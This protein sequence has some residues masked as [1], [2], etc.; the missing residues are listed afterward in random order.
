M[1]PF[2]PGFVIN[3]KYR[4]TGILGQGGMGLVYRAVQLGLH[5]TVALKVTQLASKYESNE[6]LAVREQRFLREAQMCARL[7]H[8]NVVTV[9]DFGEVHNLRD[10]KSHFIAMEYLEGTTLEQRIHLNP[11]GM[12]SGDVVRLILEVARGLRAA[13]ARRLV[14]RDLKPANVMMVPGDEKEQVKILDFGLVL[15]ANARENLTMAG[16]F[17]G[18]PAYMAPEQIEAGDVDQQVDIYALGTIMYECLVGSL[19]FVCRNLSELFRAKAEHK[20]E[21]ISKRNPN[22]KVSFPL[23]QLTLKMMARERKDRIASIDEVIKI[24][25]DTPEA[26]QYSEVPSGLYQVPP[27]HMVRGQVQYQ[28]GRQLSGSPRSSVFQ[29]ND[30]VTGG[31]VVVKIFHANTPAEKQLLGRELPMLCLLRNYRFAAVF[32][33]GETEIEQRKVPFLVME[34]V[35]GESLRD[36]QKKSSMISEGLAIHLGCEVLLALADAHAIRVV[37]RE[38]NHDTILLNEENDGLPSVKIIGF[39]TMAPVME[40]SALRQR[41]SPENW[42]YLAPESLGTGVMDENSDLFALAV[43]LFEGLAGRSLYAD[44]DW[45]QQ[46]AQG[47]V[48]VRRALRNVSATSEELVSVIERALHEDPEKRFSSARAFYQALKGLRTSLRQNVSSHDFLNVKVP[49]SSSHIKLARQPKTIWILEGD[50][51][52]QAEEVQTSLA[53]LRMSFELVFLNMDQR[54]EL[55]PM[56]QSGKVLPPWL[57]IFGDL[58]VLLDDELLKTLSDFSETSK[59]IISSHANVEMLQQS[60]NFCGLDHQVCLPESATHIVQVIQSMM[61][62]AKRVRKRKDGWHGQ[63]SDEPPA[64]SQS[65]LRRFSA[66]QSVSK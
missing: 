54:N 59:L 65:D 49:T 43:I 21:A 63:D 19:P 60:I 7:N 17:V 48:P 40:P 4:I 45:Q 66:T 28:L 8:P 57:T 13:H 34:H 10:Q 32:F 55:L 3:D 26:I 18:S 5:R 27:T 52:F 62:R 44:E 39:S 23:E 33:V 35:R 47:K 16:N 61:E 53:S 50:P 38:L 1:L 30:V 56:V 58:I 24:L 25:S 14:H 2:A 29:A 11:K 36:R 12:D 9:F 41:I 64:L 42:K 46:M 31:R 22:A 51:A 15:D 37:H 20:I 6:E